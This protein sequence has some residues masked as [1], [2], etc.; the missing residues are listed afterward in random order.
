MIRPGWYKTENKSDAEVIVIRGNFALGVIHERGVLHEGH[1]CQFPRIWYAKDGHV[2]EPHPMK[3]SLIIPEPI[4]LD[5][6]EMPSPIQQE[7]EHGQTVY[8]LAM[9]SNPEGYI[10]KQYVLGHFEYRDWFLE[11]FLFNSPEECE[12]WRDFIVKKLKGG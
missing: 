2:W 8:L 4:T 12:Q 7:P 1:D 6:E 11:G 5:G 10:E 9:N 3:D